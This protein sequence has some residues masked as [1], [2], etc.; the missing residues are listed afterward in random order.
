MLFMGKVY[1]PHT[2]E[3]AGMEPLGSERH[4]WK[5]REGAD[6]TVIERRYRRSDGGGVKAG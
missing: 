2:M 5:T 3:R 1:T 4:R 6:S